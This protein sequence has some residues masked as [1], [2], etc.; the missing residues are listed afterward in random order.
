MGD[1]C[2]LKGANL[3]GKSEI[4]IYIHACNQGLLNIKKLFYDLEL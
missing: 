1:Y 4:Y 3:R 2:R